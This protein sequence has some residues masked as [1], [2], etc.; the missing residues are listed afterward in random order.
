MS[1]ATV[2]RRGTALLSGLSLAAGALLP[3]ALTPAAD[4]ADTDGRPTE[5]L[6]W[7]GDV[8]SA[9]GAALAQGPCDV[10]GDGYDDTTVGAWF[11]DKADKS[12]IGA[13]YV[14]LGSDH[15]NGTSLANPTTAGAVRIDG[16]ETANAF[17][18]F[19]VGCLGD[20]NGDGY[21]D[22]GISHY[23]AEKVYV[24]L[25]AE[26]FTPV[27]L[28]AL[29]DRGYVVAGDPAG[30][31]N[32]GYS[33][34]PV[35]DVNGDHRADFAVAGI[36]ADTQ[37]RTNNGRM[38]IVAG[39]D[40]IADVSLAS[41][42]DGQIIATIDGASSEERLGVA[43]SVG[44][45]NGDGRD[46]ILLGSYTA[47]PWGSSVAV[48]GAA[49]VVWGGGPS[50]VDLAAL[51]TAGFRINGPLRQR[52]RLG[53]SVS[54]A[55]DLNKDGLA[56]LLI[57]ADGVTNSSTG[58][59]SG[60]AAVVF[61][62]AS[63]ATVYT[64]PTATTSVYTCATAP[65]SATSAT[66]PTTDDVQPRGYWINGE[67]TSDSAGYSV[68][69]PG[70]VNGDT[71]PDL[72]IGAYGFDPV[73]PADTTKTMSG[74]GA[75]YVVFGKGTT[76][77]QS[78]AG[79]ASSAGY[80]IDGTAAG[81]RFGRQVAG[82]GDVDG[83]GSTDFAVGA[84]FANRGGAQAGEVTLGLVGTLRSATELASSVATTKPG[85]AVTL[86]ATVAKLAGATNSPTGTVAFADASGTIAGCEAVA[87]ASGSA[88]C[89]YTPATAGTA[90]LTATYSGAT[91]LAP[92]TSSATALT[93]TPFTSSVQ[94]TAPAIS[95]YG[96]DWEVAA[97][98]SSTGSTKP[99]GTVTFEVDGTTYAATLDGSGRASATIPGTATKAGT[100][101]ITAGYGGDAVT[102]S[103]TAT[104][105]AITITKSSTSLTLAAPAA[106]TYGTAWQLSATVTGRTGTPT[107]TVSFAIGGATYSATLDAD[108]HATAT[109]PGTAAAPGFALVTA[110]YDGDSVGSTS[111]G[112]ALV[113]VGKAASTT[114][115]SVRKARKGRRT[116]V[117]LQVASAAEVSGTVRIGVKARGLV[118]TQAGPSAKTITLPRLRRGRHTLVVTYAGSA[119]VSGS[120]ARVRF[121]VR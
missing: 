27:S 60:G 30:A 42:A 82:L 75:A 101:T 72:L 65:A 80:R 67:V 59:R 64:D 89:S 116:V 85:Q 70:D 5:L 84:D 63:T 99:T 54:G 74:A 51:G 29:G 109:I 119:T 79:L 88:T 8:S 47:T 10:N 46:D 15:V 87:L 6:R 61:G 19:A 36:V 118:V 48:P 43:S 112:S 33:V 105:T 49:Y 40:D 21:D 68:S 26:D 14:L 96:T 106:T 45:V 76:E 2:S 108:G 13:T 50:Q 77:S 35:G 111:T 69:A 28:S 94:I 1:D 53:I 81:D 102:A 4:A 20:V 12:N 95:T 90:S 98:V 66:C 39:Q 120:T 17:T 71:V 11:W 100:A 104:P 117:T 78:L 113:R 18:G 31:A 37:G 110:T 57:G 86:T 121:V 103:G 97:T 93:V 44:D 83:N 9:T 3:L 115:V 91:G 62:S 34:A 52:D 24:V 92:S 55:G 56:D 23:T 32:T 114:V 16:P 7:Q 107:G 58:N 41:P 25:G 22:I 73:N 38:W